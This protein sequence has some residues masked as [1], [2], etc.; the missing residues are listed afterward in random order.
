VNCGLFPR[1]RRRERLELGWRWVF[2]SLV[3]SSK[4]FLAPSNSLS[5]KFLMKEKVSRVAFPFNLLN[6]N[7]LG[8]MPAK[9]C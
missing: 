9:Y 5:A 7:A 8:L 1:W 4:N 3:R 2:R 6:P